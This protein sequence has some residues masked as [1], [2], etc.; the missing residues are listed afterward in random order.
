[1]DASRVAYEILSKI[2]FVIKTWPSSCVIILSIPLGPRLVLI[3]L[4]TAIAALKLLCLTSWS[5]AFLTSVA[6]IVLIC[7]I[8]SSTRAWDDFIID[9]FP[10]LR[11]Y[12]LIYFIEPEKEFYI[13]LVYFKIFFV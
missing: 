11:I 1:M 2:S 13:L 9:D 3:K 12:Y 8:A 10:I 6:L 4:E 7:L 5:F